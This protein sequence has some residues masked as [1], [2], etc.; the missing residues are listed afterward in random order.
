VENLQNMP[1]FPY[2]TQVQI[3]VASMTLH[4][5]IQRKS[6]QDVAFNEFDRHLDFVPDDILTDV[7]SR[8][9]TCGHQRASRMNYVCDGIATCLMGQKF[10]F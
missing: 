1:V 4:N 9:Q 5:Y 3:V 2:K 8:S 7:V 10:F 6:I